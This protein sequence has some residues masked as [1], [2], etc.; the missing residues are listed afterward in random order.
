MPTDDSVRLVEKVQ[1]A[2]LL[3]KPEI[4]VVRAA[5]FCHAFCARFFPTAVHSYILKS[6]FSLHHI[7]P[8]W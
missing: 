8:Q 7:P 6:S 4:G 5:D 2:G 1:K 3:A